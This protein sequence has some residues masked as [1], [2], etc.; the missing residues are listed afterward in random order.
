MADFVYAAMDAH[1]LHERIQAAGCI[2]ILKASRI[3]TQ[4]KEILLAGN[5]MRVCQRAKT[6]VKEQVF[7]FDVQNAIRALE[8]T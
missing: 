1:V 6:V 7:T 4:H 2:I 3:S 5:A 8:K